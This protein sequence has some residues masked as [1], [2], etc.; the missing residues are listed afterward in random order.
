MFCAAQSPVYPLIPLRLSLAHTV[1]FSRSLSFPHCIHLFCCYWRFSFF[2]FFASLFCLL[3]FFFFLCAI[4]KKL[5]KHPAGVVTTF[6]LA[7]GDKNVHNEKSFSEFEE[8]FNL[9]SILIWKFIGIIK[10]FYSMVPPF[11]S[12]YSSGVF[13]YFTF[14]DL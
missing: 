13:L 2:R 6:A 14:C 12:Y 4:E 7:Q 10:L 5:A 8:K 3:F 9:M 11:W 1:S